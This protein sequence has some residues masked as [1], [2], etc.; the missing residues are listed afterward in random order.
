MACST[1]SFVI[2]RVPTSMSI[3]PNSPGGIGNDTYVVDR[4]ADV[5]SETST[6]A[7]EI[8]SVSA[9]VSHTL[10]ANVENLTLTGTIAINGTGNSLNKRIVGNSAINNLFGGDGNDTLTGDAGNDTLTG[11]AGSDRF[12]YN[13]NAAFTTNAFGLDLFT[14]FTSGTDK[15][16]LDKTTFTALTSAAGSGFSASSEFAIVANDAAVSTSGALIAYSSA[17]GKIFYNQDRAVAGLG[18]GGQFATVSGI[19]TLTASDFIIQ[20]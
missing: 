15:L 8:D 10:S 11:G 4:S 12:V 18:S 7:T 1:R 17:T 5:V 19:P 16:V 20:A 2:T 6:T 13:S 3:Y 14:D 9:S